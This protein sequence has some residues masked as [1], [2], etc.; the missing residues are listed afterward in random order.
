MA[1]R[2][3]TFSNLPT[4]MKLNVFAFI[5]NDSDQ[6]NVCLV[7]RE[8]RSLM[9][10]ILWE[11]L[12]IS[13][14]TLCSDQLATLLHPNN[15]VLRNVRHL[16]MASSDSTDIT[17]CEPR[18]EALMQLLI[19][20]LPKNSLLALTSLQAISV[21]LLLNALQ[22]QQTL[23]ELEICIESEDHASHLGV[24]VAAH[25]PWLA[26]TL[27][28]VQTMTIFLDDDQ[29]YTI[30]GTLISSSQQLEDLTVMGTSSFAS[31][32]HRGGRFDVIGTPNATS[33][34]CLMTKLR[35]LA[36]FGLDLRPTSTLDKYLDST[37]LRKLRLVGCIGV[38]PLLR[39]L[40]EAFTRACSLQELEV[41]SMGITWEPGVTQAIQGLLNSF[42]GI[43]HLW[44]ALE[45]APMVSI[46][47]LARHGSTLRQLGLDPKSGPEV[48]SL[49]NLL[50]ACPHL[51]G[52]AVDFG[53]IELGHIH[54][55]GSDFT[56]QKATDVP[57]VQTRLE[58]FLVI[59]N[60]CN[61]FRTLY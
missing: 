53:S 61:E 52:L 48:S 15:G 4:E 14:D 8:W 58:A 45:E 3:K 2:V 27:S 35:S 47:C 41:S 43:K 59:I 49:V 9:A 42:S 55:L 1:E 29:S 22:C 23:E 19:G 39:S 44:L 17:A 40:A 28:G 51:E 10:P 6:A 37:R 60:I 21:P 13:T 25:G 46:S 32:E 34:D 24:S 18:L 30:S 57:H 7:S 36:L 56:L 11:T 20:A 33:V 50:T 5:R 54:K 38:I 12:I 31:L 26:P 16:H